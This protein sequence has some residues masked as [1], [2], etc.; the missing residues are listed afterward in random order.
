MQVSLQMILECLPPKLKQWGEG[1]VLISYQSGS[2]CLGH[3]HVGKTGTSGQGSQLLGKGGSHLRVI[4]G[5]L[6]DSTELQQRNLK[7]Y[8]QKLQLQTVLCL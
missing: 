8:L 5:T 7:S 1:L 6:I 2:I 4:C 3:L